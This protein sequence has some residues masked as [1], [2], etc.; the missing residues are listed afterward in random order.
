MNDP[1][2]AR[3]RHIYDS[4][5]DLWRLVE[6]SDFPTCYIDE[7]DPHSLNTYI[8]PTRNGECGDGW[9]AASARLIHWNLEWEH[10]PPLPGVA[11]VWCS[12]RWFAEA[13]NAR[14]VPMGSHPRLKLDDTVEAD[15]PYDIAFLGYMIPRRQQIWTDMRDRGLRITTNGA[16]GADRHRLLEQSAVY[17][18]IHQHEH[19]PGMPPLRLVVAAAYS[20][21]FITETVA[22]PGIFGYIHFM[23]SAYVQYADF[24]RLWTRDYDRQR[25]NDY[26]AALHALLCR[27]MTFRRS[28][29]VAL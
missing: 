11:E 7:I 2:F 18:H 20:M 3:T 21:P 13:D 27:D 16:W 29:E 4:Y 25:L 8:M 5:K 23:Q 14:Y 15:A 26:G 22:D 10:Y 1:I 17:G 9:L 12:D 19:A 6:L 28:V 24:I